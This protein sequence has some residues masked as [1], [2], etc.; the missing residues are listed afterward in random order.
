MTKR[1]I[2]SLVDTAMATKADIAKLRER[3]TVQL[4]KLQDPA[5]GSGSDRTLRL[6]RRN[7]V[8]EIV[9]AASWLAG[10]LVDALVRI[11]S[12]EDPTPVMASDLARR[13]REAEIRLAIIR[14]MEG[15]LTR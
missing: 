13:I 5:K 15:P 4:E 1:P 8:E 7:A 10:D 14:E 12:G 9:I 11:G 3:A 2:L 6:E